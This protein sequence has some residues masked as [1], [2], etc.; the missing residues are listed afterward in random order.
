MTLTDILASYDFSP[1]E[2][3]NLREVVKPVYDLSKIKAGQEIR[4][5]TTSDGE[6][7]SLEYDIDE[8]KYL[9]IQKKEEAFTAE[10]KNIPYEN[11]VSMIW[12]TIQDN[13]ISA[14]KKENEG[15]QLALDLADLFA[16]DID[17]YA[18]LRKDDSFKII[19]EKKYLDGKF[20]GYGNAMGIS[21]L[22]NSPTRRKHSRLFVSLTLIQKN[23][24]I[25][26]WKAI[27]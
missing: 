20:V 2:I 11:R 27:L 7:V 14:V 22:R 4:I 19:F 25:S 21:L 3:Y 12:G 16:W 17:F 23:Q 15:V 9:H 13:P 1:V 8:K 10:I 6:F 26:T 5:Y 24:T 18:D